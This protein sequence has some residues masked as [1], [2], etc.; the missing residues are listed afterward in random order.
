MHYVGLGR[1]GLKVSRI[2]LGMKRAVELGIN[3][4]DTADMYSGG[5]PSK[6]LDDCCGS[7]RRV[8]K[9]SCGKALL[10]G[11]SR[12]QGRRQLTGAEAGGAAKHERAIG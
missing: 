4:F 5:A 7:L 11:R 9:S 6:S 12:V 1:S 3:V 10:P 8:M 2:A